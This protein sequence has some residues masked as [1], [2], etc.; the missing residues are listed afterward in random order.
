MVAGLYGMFSAVHFGFWFVTSRS[1]GPL[2]LVIWLA[3][4]F[5]IGRSIWWLMRIETNEAPV[6]NAHSRRTITIAASLASVGTMAVLW[7]PPPS[8]GGIRPTDLKS[9][10]IGMHRTGCFG[11]CPSYAIKIDGNGMVEYSGVQNVAVIGV[12]RWM[13]PTGGVQT[14]VAD[15]NNAGF[16]DLDDRL[17]EGC[18]DTPKVVVSVAMGKRDKTV[19]SDTQC[20]GEKAGPQARFVAL[21]DEIDQIARSSCWVNDVATC[22]P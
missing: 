8:H 20:I 14:L 1:V 6:E 21:S 7:L 2:W 22:A 13:I 10:S 17:F 3:S 12:R 5:G 18:D 16:L 4:A 9:V 15:L 19:T 11:G